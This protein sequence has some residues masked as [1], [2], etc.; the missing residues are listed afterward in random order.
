MQ[1]SA[2]TKLSLLLFVGLLTWGV[3]TL[4]TYYGIPIHGKVLLSERGWIAVASACDQDALLCRGIATAIPAIHYT[5]VRYAPFLSY[6]LLS[7][8]L[9]GCFLGWRAFKGK[10]FSFDVRMKPWHVYALFVASLWLLFTTLS[11]GTFND[12]SM[13]RVI[14]P[15]PTVYK[16][17][18]PEALQM[19]QQNFA[20]LE[21]KNC[22]RKTRD[23]SSQVGE[24]RMKAGCIQQF[25]VTRVLTQLAFL[26]MLFLTFLVAG[27]AT[28]SLARFSGAKNGGVLLESILCLGLGVCVSI[29]VLWILAVFGILHSS[30]TWTLM[31]GALA[32]GYKH[33]RYWLRTFAFHTWEVRR[34]WY[35]L[36]LILAFL[37]ISYFAFNFLTVIRPFPIGWDDLGS[38]L[39]RPRLLVSY[40]SFIHKMSSFQWEYISSIGYLL[41]GYDSI[42]GSTAAMIINWS[43]GLFA[44]LCILV[45][46]QTFLG[47]GTGLIAA[48]TYYTLPVIGHF[49]FAD[50]KTDNAVFAFQALALLCLFIFL[51]KEQ[52]DKHTSRMWLILSGLF[53][54]FA[55]GTK[56]TAIMVLMAMFAILAGALLHWLAFVGVALLSFVVFE[57]QAPFR[58]AEVLERTGS[59]V[60]F[61]DT[62]VVA[63]LSVFGVLSIV[64]AMLRQRA[65]VHKTLI[66]GSIVVLSFMAGVA[67]WILH[68]NIRAGNAL[69]QFM[70]NAPDTLSPIIDYTD[71]HGLEEGRVLRNLPEELALDPTHP[72]CISTATEE[73]LGRYWGDRTGWG[74]YLTL[75]WRSVMNIDSIGYYVTSAPALLLFPLLLLIP[76]FWLDKGRWF[77]WLFVGTVFLVVEWIFL[78]NGVP[79][80]GIGMFLGLAIGLELLYLHAPDRQNRILVC[81]LLGGSLL[82][83]FAMRAW[84]FEQQINLLEYPMGKASA[85]VMRERTIPQYDEITD[86]VLERHSQ[87][88]DRPYL[89]RVGT[90]IP[91]FLP[92]NLEVIGLT[93]HQL[94]SFNC[95]HQ[96]RNNALTLQRLQALGFNSIIFDTNTATIERDENGSLHKKVQLFVDFLNDATL[97]LTLV[98]NDPGRGVVYVLIP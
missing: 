11:S 92:R 84:Q 76:F 89:F 48:L 55:F 53:C 58:L 44:V 47:K 98:V 37:L 70:L 13:R 68:N 3:Y 52:D 94:D 97:G 60:L 38:Y 5:F 85:A 66:A 56:V 23:I 78:A 73:E 10:G 80:Y 6:T 20:A 14:E 36:L 67:P 57:Y 49:S 51:F 59:N 34:V 79:W 96:E 22:L 4:I 91:Y 35:S 39:N 15:H 46:M 27:R 30:I 86:I 40:G 50:M 33:T 18:N 83:C 28:L 12:V 19:L 41:Y 32:G 62:T 7:V 45:F 95:I 2:I 43:A 71:D 9:Y 87:I 63:L 65:A 74:H 1:R 24:Y 54:A 26:T 17:D 72:S 77:R 75:P 21:E 29:V 69:P 81:I 8:V 61:T 42:F 88:A 82:S 90:F 31:F 64:I 16:G 93:D 25:F